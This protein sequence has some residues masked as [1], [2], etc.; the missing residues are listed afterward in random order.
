MNDTTKSALS[1][2]KTVSEKENEIKIVVVE[3]ND[4]L[5]HFISTLLNNEYVVFEAENGRKGL[6]IIKKELPDIVISDIMMP[7]VDGIELLKSVKNDNDLSHIPV[8]LLSAKSAVDDQI[9][10]LE[11]GADDYI[12]KPFSAG[13]LK[14]KICSL[15]K[16]RQL[17]Y[18]FYT[19]NQIVEK[20]DILNDIT[21]SMP[22]LTHFDDEFINN[23]VKTVEENLQ[24]PNFTIDD[25]AQ[26]M[27][28]SRTVFYRKVK[29]LLGV[30]PVDFVKNMRVKRA[31][32]LLEQNEFSIAEI[33]YM[34]GFSTPQYFNKVFKETM[35]C[36]PKEYK[37]RS[38]SDA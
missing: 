33:G 34:S 35:S 31:G 7:D 30:S 16:Q 29:S 22:Q 15:L 17:L 18:N 26:A 14:T 37:Q 13:Y 1:E 9:N 5:R 21:P 32:Q 10:G 11:F 19:K 38:N 4:E 36:T 6:D 28:L 24:N 3:D 20:N 27:N 23:M 2:I 8:I 25:L 12:T